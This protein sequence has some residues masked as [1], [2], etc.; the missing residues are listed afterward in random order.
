MEYGVS[1]ARTEEEYFLILRNRILECLCEGAM[2]RKPD[3]QWF[4]AVAMVEECAKGFFDK[5]TAEKFRY[6]DE[7]T[8]YRE[9]LPNF[10]RPLVQEGLLVENQSDTFTI[11]Q[12]SLLRE[13]CPKEF[14]GK[15]YIEWDDFIATVRARKTSS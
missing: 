6:S 9:V 4:N 2:Q 14:V 11:P 15:S 13:I 7:Q 3:P 8:Y 10:Y 12:D 1:V 5:E